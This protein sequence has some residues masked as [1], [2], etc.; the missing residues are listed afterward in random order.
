M[1][2]LHFA[3]LLALS[4]SITGCGDG[5]GEPKS[6]DSPPPSAAEIAYYDCLKQNGQ[7][8]VVRDSGMPY[9]DK[10]RPWNEAAHEACAA[11]R[12]ARPEPERIGPER[13]AALRRESTCL[14]AEGLAWYPDP[15][16]VTG[17]IDDRAATAEQ[18]ADLKR[19]HAAA[20]GKCRGAG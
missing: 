12:P 17:G 4:L 15:D 5:K 1:R 19:N 18:W 10:T 11:K 8:V 3:P 13:L 16:P 9:E 7:P 2:A 20:L 6:E 14:R